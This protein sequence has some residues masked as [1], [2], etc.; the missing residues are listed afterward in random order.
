MFPDTRY[1]GIAISHVR[2]QTS[3]KVYFR[4][5]F[6]HAGFIIHAAYALNA[7]LS[8]NNGRERIYRR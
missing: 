8:A 1:G 2:V 6:T 4:F 3:L 7:F 5:Y